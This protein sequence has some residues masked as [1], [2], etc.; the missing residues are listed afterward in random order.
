[1]KQKSCD[2]S[3][4]GAGPSGSIAASLLAS[5]GWQVEVFESQHFPRFSIGESLLP[6][7]VTLMEEAGMLAEVEAC[8]FQFK[9]GAVFWR[10]GETETIDFRK[11]SSSGPATVYQ[12]R[13]DQ[14]DETLVDCAMRSGARMHFGHRATGFRPSPANPVLT[15][16]N[17]AG[18]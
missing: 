3:I 11:K 12:V 18:E 15:V 14:F 16:E 4:I 17:E 9:D 10:D 5:R 8:N 13:R 6:M 2:V 7:C 1:M